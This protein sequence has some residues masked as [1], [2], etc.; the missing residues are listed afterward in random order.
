MGVERG[1]WGWNHGLKFPTVQARL[2]VHSRLFSSP[3]F[4][5]PLQKPAEF[6]QII[7]ILSLMSGEEWEARLQAACSLCGISGAFITIPIF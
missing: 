6:A 2:L 5:H 3:P 1:W 7:V 4:F